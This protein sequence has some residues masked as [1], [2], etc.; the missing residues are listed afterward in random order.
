M[1]VKLINPEKANL[2]T[3]RQTQHRFDELGVCVV[4]GKY[5][6]DIAMLIREHYCT[7]FELEDD[8]MEPKLYLIDFKQIM[9]RGDHDD[10]LV[11][12]IEKVVKEYYQPFIC[13]DGRLLLFKRG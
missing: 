5:L 3:S 12:E 8:G 7:P 2:V 9:A 6:D 13:K 1:R 10:A 4:D 11:K